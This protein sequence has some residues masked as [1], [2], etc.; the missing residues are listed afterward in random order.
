MLIA[1]NGE[2]FDQKMLQTFSGCENPHQRQQKFSS[3]LHFWS[4]LVGLTINHMSNNFALKWGYFGNLFRVI[5]VVFERMDNGQAW[6]ELGKA[7]V[8]LSLVCLHDIM[9]SKQRTH[10][11]LINTI[12]HQHGLRFVKETCHKLFNAQRTRRQIVAYFHDL[13]PTLWKK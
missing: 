5:N 4:A 2:N 3:S 1:W 10:N 13:C 8:K 11:C 12:L 6:D 7:Q 9:G